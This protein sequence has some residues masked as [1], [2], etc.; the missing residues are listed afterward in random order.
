MTTSSDWFE[1]VAVVPARFNRLVFY[2]G[3]VFHSAHVEAPERL[4]A[5]PRAGRLTMN[6]FYVCRKGEA[7]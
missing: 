7:S 3:N 6:G 4:V 5:D 2:P 1:R